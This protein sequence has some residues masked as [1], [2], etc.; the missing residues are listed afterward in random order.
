MAVSSTEAAKVK[1]LLASTSIAAARH[2]GT[3]DKNE[4]VAMYAMQNRGSLEAFK[5]AQAAAVKAYWSHCNEL[6]I[7]IEKL[8]IWS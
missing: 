3:A 6:V 7:G 5:T 8:C 4:V 1:K 2:G